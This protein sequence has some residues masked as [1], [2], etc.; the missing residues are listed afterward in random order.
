MKEDVCPGEFMHTFTTSAGR[1]RSAAASWCPGAF[2]GWILYS[3]TF[4]LTTF[5]GNFSIFMLEMKPKPF[6][7][8]RNPNQDCNFCC[9]PLQT[10]G[11]TSENLLRRLTALPPHPPLC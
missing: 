1:V 6:I 5:P 7:L 4:I 11:R 2:S 10:M 3:F 8:N 9:C